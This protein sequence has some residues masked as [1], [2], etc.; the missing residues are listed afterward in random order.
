MV[1]AKQELG[2]IKVQRNVLV[3]LPAVKRVQTRIPVR[4]VMQ[5]GTLLEIYVLKHVL[6]PNGEMITIIIAIL[7]QNLDH[8]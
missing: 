5:I 4:V 2:S 1:R 6:R 7:V 8:V 3:V